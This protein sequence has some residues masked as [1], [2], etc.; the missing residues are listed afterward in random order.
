MTTERKI[1]ATH[2][3]P[4]IPCRAWD[5]Q[6]HYDDEGEEAGRYGWGETE[7]AAIK[8]LRSRFDD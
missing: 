6:A 5:W 2:V 8:D 1:I 3:Y 7:E 4:P